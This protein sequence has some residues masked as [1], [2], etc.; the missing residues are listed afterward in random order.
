MNPNVTTALPQAPVAPALQQLNPQGVSA[1]APIAGATPTQL[2]TAPPVAGTPA[3]VAT[4]NFDTAGTMNAI[5]NY[6]NIPRQTAQTV[7]A[8]QAL[9]TQ[10]TQQF[11]AQKAQNTIDIGKLQQQLDPSTYKIT[12]SS[13][14]KDNTPGAGLTITNALGQQVSLAQ[15]VNLTGADPA[16]V[17][18][19]SNNPNDQAF[20]S[21]YTNLQNYIQT[22]IAAQNGSQLAQAQL[23]D[24]YDANP[25][26]QNLELGQVSSAFMNKYGAYFGQ[27]STQ[28]AQLPQGVSPTIQSANNPATQSAYE[29]QTLLSEFGANPYQNAL[30]GSVGQSP[31]AQF[32]ALQALNP[33]P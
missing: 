4:P 33:G 15:Y 28:G 18:A 3:P 10:G 20:V 31:T 32:Q 21:A 23:A 29:N 2:P 17:L 11:E 13:N 25:G 16:T 22:R 12:Q 9:A 7:G 19:Q 6:Y 24:Y 5:A 27:P 14:T 8:G 1:P 26:L 30:A